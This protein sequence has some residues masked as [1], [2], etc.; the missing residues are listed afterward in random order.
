MHIEQYTGLV[1]SRLLF[2]YIEGDK[3]VDTRK[4]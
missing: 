3:D 1:R 4:F 2:Y